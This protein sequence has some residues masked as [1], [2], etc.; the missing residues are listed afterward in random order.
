MITN[1]LTGWEGRVSM[2]SSPLSL[3]CLGIG[4]SLILVFSSHDS[5][6][7]L[8][9]ILAVHG[10]RYIVV[11]RILYRSPSVR[12]IIGKFC[13][14]S[15]GLDTSKLLSVCRLFGRCGSAYADGLFAIPW[16]RSYLTIHLSLALTTPK[17]HSCAWL[18]Q[19]RGFSHGRHCYCPLQ[20]TGVH[21]V[22]LYSAPEIMV[23]RLIFRF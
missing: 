17:S 14:I 2:H 10:G 1:I 18:V 12:S 4:F 22:L 9:N 19:R 7:N 5:H 3:F 15:L 11:L 20:F 21:I 16:T 23:N 13:R 8:P 6:V